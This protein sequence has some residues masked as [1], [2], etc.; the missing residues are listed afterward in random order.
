MPYI[1]V[2]IERVFLLNR[3]I[4]MRGLKKSMRRDRGILDEPSGKRLE[5]RRDVLVERTRQLR[6]AGQIAATIRHLVNQG[7]RDA[8]ALRVASTWTL[9]TPI[10]H[11]DIRGGLMSAT[12]APAGQNL[13]IFR[14][15]EANGG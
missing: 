15:D 3:L 7:C 11:R 9:V 10:A 13:G 4:R 2:R 5:N 12:V 6:V 1:Q 8:G 14:D